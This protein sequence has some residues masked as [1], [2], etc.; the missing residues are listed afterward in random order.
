MNYIVRICPGNHLADA[1]VFI[2]ATLSLAVFDFNY[3]KD[4]HGRDIV[5]E[6]EFTPGTLTLVV[7]LPCRFKKKLTVEAILQDTRCRFR[8]HV[9]PDLRKLRNS[10]GRFRRNTHGVQPIHR[11]SAV[12]IGRA[13]HPHEVFNLGVFHEVSEVNY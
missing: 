2:V 5:P 6:F 10:F 11:Y 12:S 13:Q 8:A 1:T 7:T 3:A 4:Q 9:F